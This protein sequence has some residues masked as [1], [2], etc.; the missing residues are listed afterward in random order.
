MA[1]QFFSDLPNT[2]TP[3]TSSRLN[4]LLDGEEAMGNL[5]VDS[6]KSKNLLDNF[7][8]IKGRITSGTLERVNYISSIASTKNSVA[9][10]TTSTWSGITSDFIEVKQGN[11]TISGV[12]DKKIFY[13]VEAYNS[14]KV[15]Q[16]RLV[17]NNAS[18]SFNYT[19][20]IPS[21]IKY[22][23]LVFQGNVADTYTITNLM[24]E[25]GS[26]ATTY[27]PYQELDIDNLAKQELVVGN[28]RG[29]NL[30]DY[31]MTPIYYANTSVSLISPNGI[32][33]IGGN[34][35]ATYSSAIYK[36]L[37]IDNYLG[38]TITLS[39]NINIATGQPRISIGTCD[40]SGGNRV[41]IVTKDISSNGR[42]SVSATLPSST[43]STTKY[44]MIG[45]YISHGTAPTS[46]DYSE[47]T[48]IQLN[49]GEDTTY[50][51][52]QNL[53]GM[54]TYSTNEQVVGTW[55]DGK[56]IYRKV[57]TFNINSSGMTTAYTHNIANIET[58][59]PTCVAQ[60][61]RGTTDVYSVPFVYPNNAGDLL[62]W[63]VG[64]N[65][66]A[67][68]VLLYIG[69][70]M[71]SAVSSYPAIVILEYTKTTD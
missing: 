45:L 12:P 66:T 15:W 14:S 25:N 19:F 61:K 36:V 62:N 39:C 2:T 26:T 6:I 4:G 29:A 54:K 38:K 3:L 16:S 1:K 30:F 40:S 68:K 28:I 71:R 21:G 31:T 42:Y 24:I 34:S 47:F 11:Y 56:P 20:S 53:N 69:S 52:Y 17:E 33:V 55:I 58:I 18:S 44:L 35:G 50:Y 27:S 9:F 46:G 51:P 60:I 22:I 63:G 7:S 43:T 59:L 48:N 32:K 8:F 10:T 41:N 49:T 67:S 37:D 70:S 5:V 64:M 23:R 13:Y 65:I 57:V